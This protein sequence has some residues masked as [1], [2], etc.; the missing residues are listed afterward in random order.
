MMK[1]TLALRS[2]LKKCRYHACTFLETSFTSTL[3][4]V[5]TRPPLSP[6]LIENFVASVL[7]VTCSQI[8]WLANTTRASSR[9]K[10]SVELESIFLNGLDLLRN[11]RATAARVDSPGRLHRARKRKRRGTSTIVGRAAVLCATR[12]PRIG[13]PSPTLEYHSHRVFAIGVTMIWAAFQPKATT[14]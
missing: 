5:P 3:I 2:C 8:T 4:V 1:I 14:R 9:S 11:P 6:R 13:C 10:Q 12:A 7:Q